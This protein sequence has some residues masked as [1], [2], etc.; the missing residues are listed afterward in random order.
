MTNPRPSTSADIIIN[1]VSLFLLFFA[2]FA[3]EREIL[4][5]RQETPTNLREEK[6]GIGQE[7]HQNSTEIS[8]SETDVRSNDESEK[9]D[10][11]L[12]EKPNKAPLA[13][14]EDSD[15]EDMSSVSIRKSRFAEVLHQK[16]EA[17]AKESQRSAMPSKRID[18]GAKKGAANTTSSYLSS[19]FMKSRTIF[20]GQNEKSGSDLK[21]GTAVS[22]FRSRRPAQ[23]TADS[24]DL[25]RPTKVDAGKERFKAGIDE[26]RAMF[27]RSSTSDTSSSP[28]IGRVPLR[29]RNKGLLGS[30]SIKNEIASEELSSK[31]TVKE[32]DVVSKLP[33]RRLVSDSV[34]KLHSSEKSGIEARGR[35]NGEVKTQKKKNEEPNTESA[36]SEIRGTCNLDMKK[37]SAFKVQDEDNLDTTEGRIDKALQETAE[38]DKSLLERVPGNE[39][40][41]SV[42]SR[43]F[44][45][46]N[47]DKPFE[48][49]KNSPEDRQES[50]DEES[51]KESVRLERN[52]GDSGDSEVKESITKEK[53][54]GNASRVALS[55]GQT[56]LEKTNDRPL[57]REVPDEISDNKEIAGERI[58]SR[59]RR[60]RRAHRMKQVD[61]QEIEKVKE[62]MRRDSTMK[63]DGDEA[64]EDKPKDEGTV[65]L[66]EKI[67]EEKS[68]AW[69]SDG[70]RL[71]EDSTVDGV[72]I[73]HGIQGKEFARISNTV[74]ERLS[75]TDTGD[76]S[77]GSTG[78]AT[79][80][81]TKSVIKEKIKQK[82]FDK[83]LRKERTM[84]LPIGVE[85]VITP[86]VEKKPDLN[87]EINGTR[88]PLL[89]TKPPIIPKIQRSQ[90][91]DDVSNYQKKN[92]RPLRSRPKTLTQGIDPSLLVS[93]IKAKEEAVVVEERLSISQLKQ[94]L[95]QSES[96]SRTPRTP[97]VQRKNK[98]RSGKRYKTITEGI[99]PGLLEAAHQLAAN[100][101]DPNRLGVDHMN[102]LNMALSASTENLKRRS[103]IV[104][105]VNSRIGSVGASLATSM[106]DLSMKENG[107]D[108][109][110]T[111]GSLVEESIKKLKKLPMVVDSDEDDPMPSVS[112]LKQKFL[113]AVEDSYKPVKN[114][115]SR[116]SKGKQRDRPFTISGLDDVTM[117]QLRLSIDERNERDREEKASEIAES[118]KTEKVK[119]E[120]MDEFAEDEL[121]D[122]LKA[123][124][125]TADQLASEL[126][127]NPSLA[128][129]SPLRARKPFL[130]TTTEES[131]DDGLEVIHETSEKHEKDT[132]P[133]GDL[134]S[135]FVN[136]MNEFKSGSFDKETNADT[137]NE[138]EE[139]DANNTKR[140][141]RVGVVGT[142][143]Q[144]SIELVGE[145]EPK[146]DLDFV[147][148]NVTQYVH[149]L[150]YF[151]HNCHF[152]TFA[153]LILHQIVCLYEKVTHLNRSNFIWNKSGMFVCGIVFMWFVI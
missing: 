44:L 106:E 140:E 16:E 81:T 43:Q 76:E 40:N 10:S 24:S 77:T 143:E 127:I 89:R 42:S 49:S 72:H 152:Y 66:D 6:R 151:R 91:A 8:Q 118:V 15:D 41:A 94:R 109:D 86:P 97:D 14:A 142:A 61:P 56:D 138:S 29:E 112:S 137:S 50:H 18:G 98:R 87:T 26:K 60:E 46:V 148:Q 67:E 19:K 117:L 74:D 122:M 45:G 55:E 52:F 20:E 2:S 68:P 111:G 95:M 139:K 150:Y 58:G 64:K 48:G 9:L 53:F 128:Q 125:L 105:E 132:K 92:R 115:L 71:V 123:E 59:R 135:K 113:Q 27:Q 7:I 25:R 39:A 13:S 22:K 31:E 149:L 21:K 69:N 3:A 100:E 99:A 103:F 126:G 104:S 57:E 153:M 54:D 32:S 33:V 73:T 36:I 136:A 84:S 70:A 28:D 133:L 37:V 144:I 110:K 63:N 108:G 120:K 116:R 23:E 1:N 47:T 12:N 96:G 102:K 34:V 75:E 145:D 121:E 83:Q 141:R 78:S 51:K 85:V 147:S 4:E 30:K 5:A 82:K 107:Q 119:T 131:I 130:G 35:A 90:E 79:K 62:Q 11:Q 38:K 114:K 17:A 134:R 101:Q 129:G 80:L 124:G 146:S 65:T 93:D 88:S